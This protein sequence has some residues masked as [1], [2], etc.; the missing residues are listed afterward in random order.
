LATYYLGNFLLTKDKEM[1]E[2]LRQSEEKF[3]DI[4][5]N[6][7]IAIY[8]IDFDGSKI[9]TVNS[10]VIQWLGYSEE[11][12][13]A[14][15]PLNLLGEES[16]K[17]FQ[18]LVKEALTGNKTLY[19]SEFEVIAKNGQS[20][21]GLF[22]AKI[23]FKNGKPDTVLVFAQDI[24]ERKKI[25]VTCKE[26]EERFRG[27]VESTSDWIWQ[28][29]QKGDYTYASPK[30]KEILGYEPQ[31]VLGK[32]PFDLMPKKEAERI[33]KIFA[34]T[35][36]NKSTLQNLENLAIHKNGNIVVLETSGVP[37][38]DEKGNLVGYR[39][40][41][42]DITER[43]KAEEVL[44]YTKERLNNIFNATDEGITI[45]GSDGKVSDCNETSLKMLGLTREEFIGTNVYDIVVPEDRQRAMEGALKV[46]ETGRNLTEVGVLRKDGSFF[47]AEISVTALY[48]K[49]GKPI[50]FLGVVRD[51]TE[52]K[53]IEGALRDSE[54]LYRTLFDNSEDGFMLLDPIF[55]EN[56]KACDFRVL[57][58]NH[59]YEQQT[60][61]KATA[62]VGRR[63]KEV[64]PNLEQQWIAL[65]S[66]VIQTGKSE[67][68]ENYNQRTNKW[69]DAHYIPFAKGQV[70]ILFRD[71]T[72]RKK[73]EDALK[74]SEEKYRV[75][76][77]SSPVPFFVINSE[78][79]YVEVNAAACKLLGYSEKE[80]LEMTVVDV[81]FEEDKPLGRRQ[82]ATLDETGKSVMEFRLKRKDG[83]A[84]CVILNAVKLPDG[85]SMAFCENI[86]ERKKAEEAQRESEEKYRA[87]VDATNT[88]Y[89]IIDKEGRVI[90][91]NQE[92]VRLTGH[93]ELREI[94]GRSVIEWTADYEKQKNTE[95]VKQCARDGCI[96]DLVIDYVDK[97]G[98]ITPVEIN[99]AVVGG[100]GTARIISL[101]R[102]ITE[103]KNMEKQLQDNERMAAIGQTAGMIGHDIR[104]P[105]QAIVSELY[106][107]KQVMTE[108]SEGESKREGLDSIGFVEEQVNYINKIVSDLQDYAR[109][110]N[111]EYATVNLADL[112][113]GVFDTIVL[114]KTV[115]LKVDIKDNLKLKTDP[116]FIKRAITNLVNNAVQAMTLGGELG[117]A[118]YKKADCV[119]VTVS[120]TGQGIPESV[121]VNL[122]KPLMTTKAKGQ[123][124][125]LVVVKRLVEGLNGKV[126]FESGEGKGT[127]F[128]IELP[129]TQ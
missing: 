119:I 76:V 73:A 80:L 88:G 39:G 46:L 30:V 17:K 103:R 106:M 5:K 107:A 65:I 115:E 85:K 16:K 53:K 21:W 100:G 34:E 29:D 41:D 19:S 50:S 99:A 51:I 60:D 87:L 36:K 90:D 18:E 122:F 25:E 101:C 47:Q 2:F 37:L 35:A 12:I 62:I 59:A 98:H 126:S 70:G 79:K 121:R 44:K 81:V 123:G 66:N 48:D 124:L 86:T 10:A 33:A 6:A 108:T 42:R 94:L 24:T 63:A 38:V 109:P 74:N 97:N 117:L 61:T 49:N 95:A 11:E 31:E 1:Q 40:I 54:I 43:K 27:L 57:E 92:Y 75:Y 125:G 26:S 7:P 112:I 56:G 105:L 15:N 110:L 14:M 52:R 128:T 28:V 82:R 84:V 3:K 64:V 114:P 113:A 83:Q 93:R 69:Y 9:R 4:I 23:N 45:A 111:P 58:V 96:K 127:T 68:C 78:R 71:I 55:D 32:T 120:D 129:I 91:A 102:D 8:E 13:L 20:V 118:A 104:N 89:L 77:E 116:T 22:H 67:H 72:D